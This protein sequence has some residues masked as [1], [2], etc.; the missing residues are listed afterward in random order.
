MFKLTLEPEIVSRLVCPITKGPLRLDQQSGE[1]VSLSAR[2]AYPVLK[3]VPI[4]VEA[5]ARELSESEVE[6]WR[7]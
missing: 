7:K 3:G 6:A 5:E 1:L 4:L 2:L